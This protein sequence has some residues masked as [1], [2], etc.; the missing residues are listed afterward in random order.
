VRLSIDFETRST[1]DLRKVGVYAYA[2]HPTT[3]IWCMAFA[4]DEEEV[5]LWVPPYYRVRGN[6]HPLSGFTMAGVQERVSVHVLA[7]GEIR[8]WNAQ[9]ERVIWRHIL[10][11]RYGFPVPQP[12]QFVDTMIEAAAM[13][14]PFKLEQAAK[15]LGLPEQ[16]DMGGNRLAKQMAKPR[17]PRK[18]EDPAALL[19]WEDP[20]RLGKLYEYCRQDVRTER[21]VMGH[22][23]RLSRHERKLY[24]LDQEV[25]D[26]GVRID[27]PL[28]KASLKLAKKATERAN[29]RMSELTNGSVTAVTKVGDIT[30][31]LQG[32]GVEVTSLA[33]DIVRDL[34]AG[35]ISGVERDVLQ[36]RADAGK[37]SAAKLQTFLAAL[38]A[39]HRVRGL[40]QFHGAGTGRWSGRLVQPQNFPRPTVKNP[41]VYIPQVLA[42]DYDAIEAEHPVLHILASLLRSMI[43]A[44][45]GHR[46]M[47]ADFAQIEAR[48]LAWIAEQD[49]LLDL[50]ASGGKVYEDMAAYIFGVPLSEVTPEQRQ[51]GKNTVLGC[52]YQ[53]GAA[54]YR[55]Q[56]REQTGIDIGDDLSLQAVEGYRAK[57]HRIKQFWWDIETA[58][59]S[60]VLRPGT[61]A[62]VGRE[63]AIRFTKRG[64]FLWCVLPSGR[65]LAYADPIIKMRETQWGPKRGLQ[66]M[67]VNSVT[68][69]WR[70]THLYGGHLTENVVQAMARDLM[71]S[72]ML[73]VEKRGYPVVLTVHDEVLADVPEDH[74]SIEEFEALMRVRPRWARG[75]PVAA[76]A[77]EGRRYR[78]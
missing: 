37:S 11:P 33:K 45:P 42:G 2:A 30:T 8:A 58:A 76:D 54:R 22:L 63:G 60:A 51:I 66:C 52:G 36:L 41:E 26:R 16:K 38:G 17:K 3:D 4:F 49:D 67:G 44:S 39:D 18:N 29:V 24:L 5:G 57:N 73:R 47:G 34:L 35:D 55:E 62:H 12:D 75:L 1:V 43:T 28:V 68:K 40:L 25:N 65:P 72:A 56:A 78:K 53:M 20:E 71:A 70:V 13:A 6:D 27:V 14:L 32:R 50:F 15:V 61:V 21:G 74:G 69:Q 46:L 23:R 59:K 19:W 9:F 64:R 48:V 10:G 31:W 7:G 77:W